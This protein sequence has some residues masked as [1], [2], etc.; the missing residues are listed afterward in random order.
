MKRDYSARLVVYGLPTLDK[1]GR[2]QLL[3]WL[4]ALQKIARKPEDFSERFVARLMK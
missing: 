3:G 1:R 4:K 2:R